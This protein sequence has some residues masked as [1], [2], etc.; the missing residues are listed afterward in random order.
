MNTDAGEKHWNTNAHES[1]RIRTNQF[2]S[3]SV[4]IRVHS[5]RFVSIRVPHFIAVHRCP[6]GGELE[7]I[8]D[9]SA[10]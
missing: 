4:L 10:I 1:T 6:I 5:C 9:V 3:D 7:F 2:K 8:F